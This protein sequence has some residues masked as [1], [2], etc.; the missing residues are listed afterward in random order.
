MTGWHNSDP[1]L[2]FDVEKD[3]DVD[4]DVEFDAD[5]D[6]ESELDIDK[7]IDVCVDI[8]GN[9]ADF[10]IDIQAFGDDS[11]TELGL[12]VLVDDE[13]SSITATGFAAVD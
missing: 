7:E 6:V 12:V 8:D 1:D 13:Y 3:F 4:I 10:A 9:S 5:F 11:A 2:E